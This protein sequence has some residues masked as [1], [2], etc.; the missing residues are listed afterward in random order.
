M[1]KLPFVVEPRRQ[2][3]LEKVGTEESGM[4][5]VERRGYLTTGEKSFVQQV[6]Q[7]DSGSNEIITL[8]RQVARRYALGMDKAYMLV[9]QI[10]SAGAAADDKE[11]AL[12]SEIEQEFAEELTMVVKG[13]ATAQMRED[14]VLAACLLQYRVN[15]EFALSDIS[16]IHPDLIAGLAQLYRE[17]EARMVSAFQEEKEP[18]AKPVSIEEAEKKPSRTTGSRSKNTTGG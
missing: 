4:I 10:I 13:M 15:G 16:G 7:M 6:Q 5:E 2:P 1:I 17:E 9:L 11:A 3:I 14:L 18:E 12:I 8:S